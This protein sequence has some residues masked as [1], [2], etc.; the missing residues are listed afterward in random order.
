MK[1]GDLILCR[2]PHSTTMGILVLD[3]K[4]GGT[5]KLYD[6]DRRKSAWCVRSECRVI[7]EGR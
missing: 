5:V 1:V 4:A 7:S 6:S 2:G 3:N